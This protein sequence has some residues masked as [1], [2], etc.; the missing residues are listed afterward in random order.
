VSSPYK[1]TVH[2]F[3]VS[4]TEINHNA[5]A[6][7][8]E[9]SCKLFAD[10]FENTLKKEYKANI[11]LTHPKDVKQLEKLVSDYIQKHLQ[12]K[13]NGKQV[14]LQFIGYEKESES[15]WCYMQINNVVKIEKLEI[16]NDLLYSS[17]PSQINIMHVIVN[18]NR[19]SSK[20]NYPDTHLVLD[21]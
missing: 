2:P 4:V 7:Q 13:V 9:I 5:K 8:L 19:K 15:V 3:F 21:Y 20:L 10:D 16:M 12:F 6:S 1:E 18:G 11:D 17:N 14:S